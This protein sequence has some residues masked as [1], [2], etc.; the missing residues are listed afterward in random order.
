MKKIEIFYLKDCP[1]CKKVFSF[2]D[3]L[4]KE[5]SQINNLLVRFIEEEEENEYANA[6]D[7][8]FVPSIFI[9]DKK[10]HEGTIKSKEQLKELLL[11]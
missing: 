10:V 4:K 7:Y 3:E 11:K 8:Y 5:S 6:H 2:L 1:H 9:D